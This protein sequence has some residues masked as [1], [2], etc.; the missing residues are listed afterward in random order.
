[1]AQLNVM[2]AIEKARKDIPVGYTMTA[3]TMCELYEKNSK[4]RSCD[5]LW[6][7]LNDGFYL[8]YAQGVKATKAKMKKALANE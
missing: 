7:M 3:A 6:D 5:N 1:M 4:G 8:G 2:R